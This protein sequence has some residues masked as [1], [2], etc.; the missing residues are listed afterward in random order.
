M[1]AKSIRLLYVHIA[2]QLKGTSHRDRYLMNGRDRS[3]REHVHPNA[4]CAFDLSH[5]SDVIE[6]GHLDI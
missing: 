4:S 5:G 2:G 6:D 3:Q 1:P